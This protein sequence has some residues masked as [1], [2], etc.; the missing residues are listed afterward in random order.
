MAEEVEIEDQVLEEEAPETVLELGDSPDPRFEELGLNEFESLLMAD[1]SQLIDS[2][3]PEFVEEGEEEEEEFPEPEPSGIGAYGLQALGGVMDTIHNL[4]DMILEGAQEESPELAKAVKRINTTSEHLVFNFKGL[5]NLYDPEKPP[6]YFMEANEWNKKH[7]EGKITHW[8][9][10]KKS[11]DTG[12]QLT[13]SLTNVIS[14]LIPAARIV[15]GVKAGSVAMGI[16]KKA[17]SSKVVKGLQKF[18]DITSVGTIGSVF[19]FKPYE[20]RMSDSMAGFV[21]DTPFEVTQPFF[22]WMQSSDDNSEAE[23]RFKI[24]LESTLMDATLVGA[25]STFV[26]VFKRERKLLKAEAAGATPDELQAINDIEINSIN[27]GEVLDVIHPPSRTPIKEQAKAQVTEIRKI[28]NDAEDFVKAGDVDN[29]AG[30]VVLEA[31]TLSEQGITNVVKNIARAMASGEEVGA[32]ATMALTGRDPLINLD[33]IDDVGVK[34]II[35]AISNEIDREA[36]LLG[37]VMTDAHGNQLRVGQTGTKTFKQAEKEGLSY[38]N[39]IRRASG[40]H[41]ESL[42]NLADT[43]SIPEKQ[44][45][46]LMQADRLMA[47]QIGSRTLGWQMVLEDLTRQ[48]HNSLRGKDFDD[49]FVQLLAEKHIATITKLHEAFSEIPRGMARGLAFRRIKMKKEYL[50]KN[51]RMKNDAELSEFEVIK[52]NKFLKKQLHGRGMNRQVLQSIEE[53]M[54]VA[55]NPRGRAKALKKALEGKARGGKALQEVYRGML[56]ANLKSMTTNLLGNMMETMLIPTAKTIGH[57]A[58]FNAKGVKEEI[59]FVF[60][61]LMS[62]KR[63][64]LAG[65]DALIHERNLLDP[66]RTKAETPS[67]DAIRGFYMQMDKAVDAGYWHPHNWVALVV[68]SFGKIGR[69]SLRVLGAQDEFFKMLTYNG[70]A[71]SKITKAMPDNL[72]RAQKKT[73]IKKNLDH[74]YDDAGEAVDRDLIEYSRRATFQES[75]EKGHMNDF[76]QMVDRNP[77]TWGLVFPFVRTPANLVSRFIQRTPVANFVLSKRTR[78]M[79]NSGDKDQ[80]A[81]V[82]GNTIMG[83]GLYSA[84]L[85]YSMSGNITGSGPVDR[86]KNQLWRAAGFKPFHIKIGDTWIKYDRLEPSAMPFL[87]VATLHE[88][89]YRF[90]EDPDS[91]EDAVGLFIATTAKTLTDRTWL[92]GVKSFM[93]GVEGSIHNNDSGQFFATSMAKNF[94]PAIIAQVHRLSGIAEEDTGAFAFRQAITWQERMMAKLPPMEGYDA[95]KHNWLTGKPMMLPTGSDFGLDMHHEEPNKYMR[96]LL[97]FGQTIQPVSKKMGQIELSADQYSRLNE[98]TGKTE[99]EGR[100]LMESIEA[101]M[102][103]PEYDFDEDRAYHPDFPSPQTKAVKGLINAYKEK[104]RYD[105]L[106]EDDALFDDWQN[107]EAEKAQVGGGLLG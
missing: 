6:L 8:P 22:E 1:E 28:A 3:P 66:L 10:T 34:N 59:G 30:Q 65:F 4:G 52:R 101:L 26:K 83:V 87:Y 12:Q 82:I 91:L 23:E 44:L 18:A 53:I 94:V 75:L 24:A 96:E 48:F 39:Y 77:M 37:K 93:D 27:S 70:K 42:K 33:I 11:D 15:K 105:L 35:N 80:V 104:A 55:T 13:R 67:G 40:L 69:G 51:G 41:K 16:V 74:F 73:F 64:T 68:N 71:M 103:S 17:P 46:T 62:T 84:A 76:H 107:Q 86:E 99:M 81:E 60:N 95:I 98:L 63:A 61:M 102:D 47:D 90:R 72:S 56:L 7:S 106:E 31:S 45:F 29:K 25:Y 38:A 43:L 79:W 9:T 32:S 100:T 19:S 49:E 78:A 20:P 36:I 57:I 5:D 89:L 92:R 2:E 54:G 58:T 88:N 85:S 14:G 21:A 97:R 50:N